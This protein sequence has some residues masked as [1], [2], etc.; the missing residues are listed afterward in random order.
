M[1]FVDITVGSLL[2]K[3]IK[4]YGE[5]K[6]GDRGQVERGMDS[7]VSEWGLT[8]SVDLDGFVTIFPS[9]CTSSYRVLSLNPSGSEAFSLNSSSRLSDVIKDLTDQCVLDKICLLKNEIANME[10]Q[11]EKKRIELELIRLTRR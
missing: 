8:V 1:I 7:F 10:R 11:V 6:L 3:V 2:K 5:I 4:H 9:G